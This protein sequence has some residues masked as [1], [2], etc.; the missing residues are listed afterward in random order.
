MEGDLRVGTEPNCGCVDPSSAMNVRRT[1]NSYR[2]NVR[3]P[4]TSQVRIKR[5]ST[6]S[7]HVDRR[8]YVAVKF[9]MEV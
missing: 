1:E 5:I 9:Q 8:L 4:L 7:S 6:L 2:L 3:L